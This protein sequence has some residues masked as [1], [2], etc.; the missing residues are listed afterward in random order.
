MFD[1]KEANY[2]LSIGARRNA[3][4]NKYYWRIT[5]FLLPFYTMIPPVGQ[6]EHSG[7]QPYNG[8]A[9]VPIDNHNTWTWSFGAHPHEDYDKKTY[10]FLAGYGG[11]WGPINEDYVPVQNK[12]NDYLMNRNVQKTESFTGIEGIPN[13]DAAVQ[14][15]MGPIVDRSKERLGTSDSA[16][17]AFRKLMLQLAKELQKGK[18][19]SAAIHGDWYKVRSVSILLD[20]HVDW[21]KGAAHLISGQQLKSAA[22]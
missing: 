18:A 14:E 21:Q 12:G 4:Q 15:S 3:G 16:I 1:V 20:Q 6:F 17:I 8:H 11:M 5:Q 10:E 22:E 9:W 19:P 7:D 13:Q 2:G